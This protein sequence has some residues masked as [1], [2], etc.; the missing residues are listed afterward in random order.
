MV[1]LAAYQVRESLVNGRCL[2]V[3]RLVCLGLLDSAPVQL[4]LIEELVTLGRLQDCRNLEIGTDDRLDDLAWS[5]SRTGSRSQLL[6]FLLREG[7]G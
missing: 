3:E 6:H 7:P 4:A 2:A 1:G 5:A